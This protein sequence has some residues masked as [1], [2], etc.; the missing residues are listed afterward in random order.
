MHRATA[1]ALAIVGGVALQ[2]APLAA[3]A[4]II[5]VDDTAI[6]AN[7][8]A[9][10]NDAFTNLHEALTIAQAGDEIRIGQGT[11]K[12]A[13][14][15]SGD[16]DAAFF[17]IDGV[18][19]QG[20]FA[21]AGAAN[22]DEYDPDKF[23]TT[24]SG[25]IDG[26]DEP[27]FAKFAENSF[28]VLVA[29]GVGPDTTLKGLMIRGGN[30]DL[31]HGYTNERRAFG[32]A[33]SG[34]N[35]SRPTLIECTIRENRTVYGG[36][37][38]IR[39]QGITLRQCRFISNAGQTGSMPPGGALMLDGLAATE[40]E[41]CIFDS[42]SA[43]NFGGAIFAGFNFSDP[44]NAPILIR[45]CLFINNQS[46]EA[47][48]A[49]AGSEFVVI[50]S[51]FIGNVGSHGG[52]AATAHNSQFINCRFL[53][54]VAGCY[55]FV[56]GSAV[57]SHGDVDVINCLFSGN[58]GSLG[59]FVVNQ[60]AS[61]SMNLVANCTFVANTSQWCPGSAI[62]V[63]SNTTVT[64][65]IAWANHYEYSPP[66]TSTQS[67]Q[68]NAPPGAI[69]SNNIIEGW[70]GTLG[71][72]NN[73]GDDPIFIDAD[74]LD[75]IYG[76]E[77]DNPRLSGA[78][79]AR[80][81]GDD[82]FLPQDEFDLDGDGNTTELLPIDLDGLRRIVNGT[83][84]IG[85]YEWQRVDGCEADVAPSQPGV[86]GDGTI[87]AA[88]LLLILQHWGACDQCVGDINGDGMVNVQDLLLVIQAWGACV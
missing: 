68:I 84:D 33:L 77:D 8:G 66:P 25:D 13:A 58:Q 3:N 81:A 61:S 29:D 43:T 12:P 70:D 64:N 27:N 38:G 75:D 17:L 14:A 59:A 16:R 28:N 31:Y 32:A 79:P 52:G 10:W 46:N 71:G 9:S 22:P 74:G 41:Q 5:Y 73:S 2:A 49:I 20:G 35:G 57:G 4:A 63:G 60:S 30:A 88:D 48:G 44:P 40:I 42:N 56:S 18:L 19:M 62:N 85:A 34:I 76:T 21:G 86:A 83:V 24:L 78:S 72:T 69:L 26:N 36:G 55:T 11:Y 65:T 51:D 54:N 6:G 53:N 23:T 15:G 7:T 50:N 47:A 37:A 67:S 39:A 80:D 45:D 82:S 87:N 1:A